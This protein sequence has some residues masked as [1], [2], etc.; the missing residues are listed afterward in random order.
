MATSASGSATITE[1]PAPS[2]N[3]EPLWITAGPD[4]HLWFTQ[5]VGPDYLDRSSLSGAITE[6]ELSP[7]LGG[8]PLGLTTG[9]EGDLWLT[10]A[11]SGKVVRVT[12]SGT[13]TKFSAPSGSQ[14]AM[15]TAGPDGNLW[16]TESGG[17]GA[18][19]R[20]T[21]TGTITNFTAGLTPNSKPFGIT[22]GPE[23]NL[24]F[25]E[26]AN[27]G[28]I[29]KITTSGVITEFTSG[30]TANSHPEGIT[31]G[32]DGNLWFTE[33]ANPGRIGR[34]TPS[35][36]ITEFSTGLAA[37]VA[38]RSITT[39]NDGNLYFTEPDGSGAIGKITTSGVISELATPTSGAAT[40]DIVTGPD[41]NLWFTESSNPGR[42][43]ML[44]VAPKVGSQA[45]SA[46]ST[47]TASLEASVGPNSQETTYSFEYGTSSAYGSRTA[48][49]SAGN[50]ASSTTVAA[51]VAGLTPATLYHF[52]VVATNPTGTSYGPDETFTTGATHATEE[53]T[54]VP[55]VPS[56]LGTGPLG[57]NP[58][59]VLPPRLGQTVLAR[60]VSGTV[61]V[62]IPRTAPA[63]RLLAGEDIPVG[64]LVDASNGRLLITTA[65]PRPG[66]TQSASV[67][68]GAFVI[69]Q[70][71][72]GK[73]MTTFALAAGRPADCPAL[74]RRSSGHAAAAHARSSKTH[75]LWATDHNG[76][77]STRGQ[78]SVATVRGTDWG[79]IERC[80]GTM[81]VVRRGVV[82]VRSLRTHQ[83][84]LV[85]AGH[86]HLMK[87]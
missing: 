45:A 22:A 24:W 35:G 56:G 73:G 36:V 47:R 18:I 61:L 66:R 10:E 41:G 38:P 40:Q 23:G 34:I 59:T 85:R 63:R 49:S 28:R 81:T 43:A 20:I 9:P 21:P 71:A 84:V 60:P 12:T 74:A 27:P 55:I 30:L 25:T 68:G 39:A 29:G 67:W 72:T 54:I 2:S 76:R 78:N 44:T 1:Y 7:A 53:G 51:F 69:G 87:N 79:T 16:F 14:P 15:I 82:S 57:E 8:T 5:L 46:L 80:D 6:V 4:G 65:L 58:N 50:G 70:S 48:S 42:I 17:E 33:A 77:F 75:S 62:R 83:T 52:R 64:A 19:G 37:N 32:P 26:A 31:A 11:G 13:V 3:R 86:S